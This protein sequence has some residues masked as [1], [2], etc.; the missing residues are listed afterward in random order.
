M[1]S[2]RKRRVKSRLIAGKVLEPAGLTQVASGD[3]T[4]ATKSAN[5]V[6]VALYSTY[7]VSGDVDTDSG[8]YGA[9]ITNGSTT[10]LSDAIS[11]ADGNFSNG[12]S[13]PGYQTGETT[14]FANDNLTHYSLPRLTAAQTD[15]SSSTTIAS[16]QT[17]IIY[18]PDG[19]QADYVNYYFL[20]DFASGD[21]NNSGSI[22]FNHTITGSAVPG[23]L[24]Y[25]NIYA[26]G[27]LNNTTGTDSIVVSASDGR[28]YFNGSGSFSSGTISIETASV[29][30]VYDFD[31][32]LEIYWS[33]SVDTVSAQ[34]A[35]AFLYISASDTAIS[36]GWEPA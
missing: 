26:A 18:T 32:G 15:A 20:E 4:D 28:N 34:S 17:V 24:K 31:R 29:K 21:G 8:K 2:P 36:T 9:T 3:E 1:P 13:A 19:P 33:S 35:G 25:L 10:L 27:N 11:D 23:G 6:D 12:G 16:G 22:K 5:L 14:D 7:G 30:R